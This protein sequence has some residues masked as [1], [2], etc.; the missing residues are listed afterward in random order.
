MDFIK[1]GK[2]YSVCFSVM[3]NFHDTS[4]G[5]LS[6]EAIIIYLTLKLLQLLLKACNEQ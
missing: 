3:H 4:T 1:K 2:K 5:A 6:G